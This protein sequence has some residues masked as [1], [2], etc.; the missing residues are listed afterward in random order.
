MLVVI[1]VNRETRDVGGWWWWWCEVVDVTAERSVWR[2]VCCHRG[3]LYTTVHHCTPLYCT[4]QSSLA[5]YQLMSQQP[6]QA[7]LTCPVR[8]RLVIFPWESLLSCPPSPLPRSE[9]APVVA[10][11]PLPHCQVVASSDTSRPAV[12]AGGWWLVAALY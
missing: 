7:S 2:V 1:I 8:E 5:Q 3:R 12:A 6:R 11:L 9:P 10:T 4:A